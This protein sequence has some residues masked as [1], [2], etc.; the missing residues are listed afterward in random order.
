MA[1][2]QAGVG[3]EICPSYADALREFEATTDHL[4]GLSKE[5]EERNFDLL[6]QPEYKAEGVANLV[7]ALT[8]RETVANR[9]PL[10]KHGAAQVVDHAISMM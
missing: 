6:L 4:S 3:S 10:G 9:Y 1:Y 2:R 7:G 5:I 8:V